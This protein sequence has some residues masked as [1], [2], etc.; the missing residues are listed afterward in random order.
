MVDS[1]GNYIIIG[2]TL[3]TLF[4]D[5]EDQGGWDYYIMKVEVEQ[6]VEVVPTAAP[7]EEPVKPPA[8]KP[9]KPPV[10]QHK[11]KL[12]YHFPLDQEKLSKHL[13]WQ[14]DKPQ[15]YRFSSK[16]NRF[17]YNSL[18]MKGL[19]AGLV[20]DFALESDLLVWVTYYMTDSSSGPALTLFAPTSKGTKRGPD[21]SITV[22]HFEDHL[23]LEVNDQADHVYRAFSRADKSTLTAHNVYTL[24]LYHKRSYGQTTAY[25]FEG[26]DLTTF[27]M[28]DE[29]NLLARLEVAKSMYRPVS[30]G[31]ST[32]GKGDSW[33]QYSHLKVIEDATMHL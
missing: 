24:A 33:V 32:A 1:H 22:S 3:G 15:A 9:T 28:N 10:H 19:G 4:N 23:L 17:D 16:G 20:T 12:T 18:Q 30:I 7:S 26:G 14:G 31:L 21:A 27:D 6:P 5:Y 29:K 8:P 2:S 25:W 13:Q 11:D